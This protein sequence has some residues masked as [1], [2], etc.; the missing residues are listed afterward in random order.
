MI[1]YS[2]RVKDATT[3]AMMKPALFLLVFSL[4]LPAC[5]QPGGGGSVKLDNDDQK[6]L[7]AL[8]LLIGRNLKTFNLTPAELETV[9]AG[10]GDE[11]LGKKPQVELET[12]GPKV[13]Q[14]RSKRMSAKSEDEK[15]KGKAFEDKAAAEAGAERTPS[16][17]VF[18]SLGGG[19]GETPK[20]TDTV[21]V[22]YRGSLIDGT[23]FDS[24]YKRNQPTEFPLMGV[25]PCWTEG[26]QKMKVGEKAKL[27]CPSNIAYGDGGRPPTIP[28]GATLVF[29]I[30]LLGI[31][32]KPAGATPPM[33]LP[34]G[35]GGHPMLPPGMHPMVPPSGHGI[36]LPR[37]PGKPAPQSQ[38]QK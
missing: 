31:T 18:K 2:A 13:N 21:K 20:N 5:N 9:K 33:S 37:T 24:S 19:S 15:K 10:L 4:A 26:V 6:T 23:E 22:N 35:P 14:L 11:A 36:M 3:S 30:E 34:G 27:V 25:I 12:F 29:E 7:Y 16:G 17:M 28:G 1:I 32:T 8:G 38:P